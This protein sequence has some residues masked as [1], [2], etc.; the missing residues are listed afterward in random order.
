[1]VVVVVVVEVVVAFHAF[2]FVVV[3]AAIMFVHA[4]SRRA[5]VLPTRPSRNQMPQAS[6]TCILLVY[7][8]VVKIPEEKH[9]KE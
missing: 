2:M 1:M 5:V 9:F 3:F 7:D 6:Q 4:P 8:G